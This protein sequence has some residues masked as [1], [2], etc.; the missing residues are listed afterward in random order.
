[1]ADKTGDGLGAPAIHWY[2]ITPGTAALDPLPRAIYVGVSGDVEAVDIDGNT[3]V[4]KSMAVGWHPMRPRYILATNTTA[5][6]ILGA[7]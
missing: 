6:N 4:F 5:T 2:D 1:M 3:E 7:Y